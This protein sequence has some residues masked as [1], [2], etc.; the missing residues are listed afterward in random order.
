LKMEAKMEGK[1]REN[2]GKMEGKFEEDE[3]DYD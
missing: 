3:E 2:G 1:W